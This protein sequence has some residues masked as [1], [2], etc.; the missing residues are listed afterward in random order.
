[1]DTEKETTTA[2]EMETSSAV[3][4]EVS[5]T[6]P[7]HTHESE[8]AELPSST[9]LLNSTVDKKLAEMEEE[10]TTHTPK[11]DDVSDHEPEPG[12]G[13]DVEEKDNP[14]AYPASNP[15][16]QARLEET[17]SLDTTPQETQDEEMGDASGLETSYPSN[18]ATPEYTS[19]RADRAREVLDSAVSEG[20]SMEPSL[21]RSSLNDE[22]PES[23][24]TFDQ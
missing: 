14:A 12:N 15:H 10:E 2:G 6:E 1:M 19:F 7:E 9:G 11:L 22:T 24:S 20:A 21:S 13:A 23:S 3:T 17:D 8:K 5:K 18:T 4:P 16:I